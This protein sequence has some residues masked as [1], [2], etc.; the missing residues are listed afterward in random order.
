MATTITVG[1]LSVG[2]T[3]QDGAYLQ[4]PI[5]SPLETLQNV[6]I[7]SIV[8]GVSTII[9]NAS[10]SQASSGGTGVI[11]IGSY[12]EEQGGIAAGSNTFF[13]SAT[14]ARSADLTFNLAATLTRVSA[15]SFTVSTTGGPFSIFKVYIKGPLESTHVVAPP[16]Q[17]SFDGTTLTMNSLTPDTTYSVYLQISTGFGVVTT[18]TASTD[19]PSAS[20]PCIPAGQR[21]LTQRGLVPVEA[22]RKGDQLATAD[23]RLVDFKLYKTVMKAV[24]EKNAPIRIERGATAVELSPLH[25]IQMRRGVWAKPAELLAAGAPGVSRVRVGE[26]VAYYHMEMPD[27]LRDNMVVEGCVVESFGLPWVH[28]SGFKGS[29]YTWNARLNGYTRVAS[30]NGKAVAQ[31]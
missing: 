4:V 3:V 11:V 27:Y 9:T 2:G 20:V 19:A 13:I 21:I 18:N 1:P 22:L 23:G 25:M 30:W 7:Y 26:D 31:A 29:P 16:E 17:Y 6:E 28:R 10:V 24:A 12:V 8:N 15:S 5:T 14:D